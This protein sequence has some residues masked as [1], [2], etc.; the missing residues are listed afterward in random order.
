[1][2]STRGAPEQSEKECGQ[3]IGARPGFKLE[4]GTSV[5]QT[6]GT[7]FNQQ[8]EG[9]QKEL[10]PEPPERNAALGELYTW[11][12]QKV[13]QVGDVLLNAKSNMQNIE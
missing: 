6:Q 7:E 3:P 5:L 4:A 8:P 1:M 11:Q 13:G 12:V 9:A 10:C 2:Q